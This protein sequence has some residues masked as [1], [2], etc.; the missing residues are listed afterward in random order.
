M[1]IKKDKRDIADQRNNLTRFMM[2]GK[3]TTSGAE[4]AAEKVTSNREGGQ[5][6]RPLPYPQEGWIVQVKAS[7][8]A[9]GE[10]RSQEGQ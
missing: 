4:L 9:G 8:E 10:I 1:S 3:V 6:E 5:R 2:R 7:G